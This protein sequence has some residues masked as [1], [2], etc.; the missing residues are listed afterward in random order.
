M[1]AGAVAEAPTRLWAGRGGGVGA[2]CRKHPLRICEHEGP[3]G[4]E[5]GSCL[6]I[7]T[8][9]RKEGRGTGPMAW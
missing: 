1:V 4:V 8:Q 3:S 7:W 6:G 9:Q 5:T 2:C